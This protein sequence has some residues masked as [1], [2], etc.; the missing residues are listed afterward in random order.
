MAELKTKK[1]KA[2]VV[3][4]I[5]TVENEQKRK[6]SKALLKIFKEVTGFKPALWGTSIIGFGQYH[7]KSQRST[8]EG[9]WPLTGFSPRK[10]NISIYIM[11]GFKRCQKELKKLGKHKHSVSCLYIKKLDDIHIPT[12]KKIIRDAVKYMQEEYVHC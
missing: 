2:N 10:Q 9:D 8:Q 4:F 1:T 6:D 3:K 7:Y 11:P 5:N 12:L